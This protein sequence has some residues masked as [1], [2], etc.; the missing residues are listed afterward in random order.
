VKLPVTVG[1]RE[2]MLGSLAIRLPSHDRA[3]PW[4]FFGSAVLA[5]LVSSAVLLNYVVMPIIV[6]QGDLV[7]APDLVGRSLTEATRL[8]GEAGLSVRVVSERPDAVYLVAHVISQSPSAGVDI[9]RRR[10][11]GL[12]LSSGLDTKVVPVLVGLSARQAGLEAEEAG[13]P[14]G[15][16]V[17]VHSDEVEEGRVMAT[18]PESGT[19]LPAGT[20]IQVLVSRGPRPLEFVMPNLVGKT[21]EEARRIAEALGLVVRS[22]KHESGR[23]RLL[24]DV[25]TVQE[26]A[27]GSRVMEGEGVALRVGKG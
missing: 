12:I 25:V 26:P 6:R 8:A 10:M 2:I 9:K 17:E 5:A 20:G 22:V 13:F 11:M 4:L 23:S 24:R 1:R 19:T 7:A 15:E 16:Y 3:Q 21:P 14:V 27:P 18:Y